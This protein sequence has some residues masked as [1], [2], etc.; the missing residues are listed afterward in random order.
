[1][2]TFGKKLRDLRENKS[3]SQFELARLIGTNQSIITKFEIDKVKPIINVVKRLALTLNTSVA[4]LLDED[5][6]ST[7]V[8]KNV[9]MVKW[10]KDIVSFS[11]LEREHIFYTL[12]ALIW[13]AKTKQS[14]VS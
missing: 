5:D 2:K 14:F 1:M 3:F 9:A 6:N 11:N 4:F 7:E 12:D 8:F 10:F 13:N